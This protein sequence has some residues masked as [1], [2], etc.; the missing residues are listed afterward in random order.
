MTEERREG[1]PCK[2]L[3]EKILGAAFKVQKALEPGLLESAYEACLAHELKK[4]GLFV[5]TQ[6]AL[7]ITYDDLR[8]P[9]AYR[10]DMVVN[11]SVVLE[12]KTVERIL[13]LHQAQLFSYLRFSGKEI[14]LI[15]NF[16]SWPLKEG[17]IKRVV[18]SGS[19]G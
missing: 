1:Y 17:G 5:E 4:M 18:R 9:N 8:I 19:L 2:E 11:D 13:D 14:G 10:L 16:W 7:D 3:T 15:L 12:L 6:V